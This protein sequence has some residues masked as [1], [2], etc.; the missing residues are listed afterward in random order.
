MDHRYL[1]DYVNPNAG[2][3]H[4]LGLINQSL[5]ISRRNNLNLAFSTSQLDKSTFLQS[6]NF[7]KKIYKK[8]IRKK[9]FPTHNLNLDLN[10]LFGFERFL[11]DRAAVEEKIKSRE[12]DLISIKASEI[13]IPS[14]EQVDDLV[15]SDIDNLISNIQKNNV[16]F[17]LI[18]RDYGDYEYAST[19]DWFLNCYLNARIFN[20]I[21]LFYKKDVL[22]VAVHI[23]RG[24]LLPGNQFA[25]LSNR[26]LPDKWYLD[27]IA[28]IRNIEPKIAI[29]IFSEGREGKYLSEEGLSISWKN[30][31]LLNS[32][33]EIFEFIDHSFV[34][35][36]HHLMNADVL[37]GSKSG[38]THLA[39][40]LGD[41]IKLVP[42]MWHSYRGAEKTLELS[43]NPEEQRQLIEKFLSDHLQSYKKQI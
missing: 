5:K 6:P 17:K 2:I 32:S 25:D 16:A 29:Y 3:G 42:K 22:N 24:D 10:L 31:Y 1:I 35:T 39:G 20:P 18:N 8:I 33:C 13:P 38:M 23:R 15:Y 7:F 19:K 26:M 21:E 34:S 12:I 28:M 36:F 41:Q 9:D 11:I 40:M 43:S 4:S 14:N 30:D 27:L 37:I